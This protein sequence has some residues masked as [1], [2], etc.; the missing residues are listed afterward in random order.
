MHDWL[1]AVRV[2]PILV[3]VATLLI[4]SSTATA[5]VSAPA[6]NRD[7]SFYNSIGIGVSVGSPYERDA[8]FWGLSA[9]YTRLISGP[10]SASASLTFDQES[11]RVDSHSESVV[12]TFTLVLTVNWSAARWATLTTGLG[13]GFL[14]DDNSSGNLEFTDGD[15]G[16]GIALGISLPDLPFTVRDAVGLSIAWEYNL[17]QREPIVS[18]DLAFSWSF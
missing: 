4:A 10:W 12:N 2:L 13:K 8:W 15:W 6:I 17:T 3:P 5:Q 9:D 14:D 16:T 1:A 18:S 7:A 11:D